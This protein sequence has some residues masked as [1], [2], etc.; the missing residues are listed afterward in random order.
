MQ[1]QPG[2]FTRE[3]LSTISLLAATI[4]SVWL[5][6][7][8][9]R[10]FLPALAWALAFA[11]VTMPLYRRLE[12]RMKPAIAAFLTCTIVAVALAGPVALVSQQIMKEAAQGAQA[13][14]EQTESGEW[15]ERLRA[16]RF[17]RPVVDFIETNVDVGAQLE[18]ASGALASGAKTVLAGSFSA[19]LQ[20]AVAL[21]VLFFMLRDH[22]QAIAR[23]RS[24]MPMGHQESSD[25]IGRVTDA[26]Y[27]TVFGRLA[28]AFVQGALGGIIF[29][30]L[31]VPA[32]VLWGAV[33][34]IAAM[35][36]V[37]GAVAVWAPVALYL[38]L[39]G[40]WGKALF[41]AIFGS[42]VI[43]V[44]DNVLYPVLVG[45]KLRMHT[46]PAFLSL[47]GGIAL[48]GASGI[49]VGPVIV[50]VATALIDVWMGRTSN[51][52]AENAS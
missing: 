41:L 27:A 52:A 37:L 50:A 4:V 28:I 25:V 47:L 17:T 36:P 35:I 29:A 49:I 19:I 48:L 39:T 45:Q 10:P 14:K 51:G 16:N 30:I 15:R 18:R 20:F 9:V 22:W 31:G 23:L 21:F 40:S 13:L 26:V 8:L 33:V 46:V 24:L 2:W 34:F 12:K 1:D 7:L 43:S 38:G 11:V 5:C 3:R 44:V 42:A 6:Y 32:P